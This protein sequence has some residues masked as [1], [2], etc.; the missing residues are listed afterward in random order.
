MAQRK[1][2]VQRLTHEDFAPFGTF[3]DLLNVSGVLTLGEPPIE[4][5]PDILGLDTN[6]QDP[7]FSICRVMNR[8]PVIDKTEFHHNCGEGIL[9]LDDDIYIHVGPPTTDGKP[10]LDAI[11]VFLARKG[12]LV[13]LKPDV[14]H[15]APLPAYGSPVNVLIVLPPQ[16][17]KND[18]VVVD[19][20]EDQQ[21]EVTVAA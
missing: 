16:T 11:K 12:T 14:W 15:H 6:G 18:C 20:E 2:V 9:P 19:L 1:V 21:I 3:A 8:P 10:P 4:F 17:Y 13:V 5:M 7:S